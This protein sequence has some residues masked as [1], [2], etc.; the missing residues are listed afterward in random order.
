[1]SELGPITCKD[2]TK[3]PFGLGV[4]K[5]KGA[6]HSTLWIKSSENQRRWSQHTLDQEF[7]KPKVLVTALFTE[8]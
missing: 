4:R 2:F 6:G 7:G 5:T 8:V 1:M 3:N